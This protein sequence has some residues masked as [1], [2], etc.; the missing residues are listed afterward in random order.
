M[1]LFQREEITDDDTNAEE[2]DTAMD[3]TYT[4]KTSYDP[5]DLPVSYSRGRRWSL[6]VISPKKLFSRRQSTPVTEPNIKDTFLSVSSLALNSDR[7]HSSPNVK[8][9]GFKFKQAHRFLHHFNHHHN[10]G[11]MKESYLILHM[12]NGDSIVVSLLC[13]HMCW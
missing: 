10:Q 4:T 1:F 8:V 9:K 3:Q 6:D 5:A 7:R 13:R 2:L 11:Q 12:D